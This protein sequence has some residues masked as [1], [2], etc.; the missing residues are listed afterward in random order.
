MDGQPSRRARRAGRP[1]PTAPWPCASR[2]P[3][4]SS[5][6]EGSLSVK[7]TDGG[8]VETLVKPIPI[9][10][11]KLEVEFYPEGGDLVA[12]AANRV[13]FQARTTLGKPADL[14][15]PGRGRRPAAWSPTSRR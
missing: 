12:G 11:K 8:N 15:G 4:R 7:F 6:G 5:K 14:E 3:S 1:A 9:V 2:C 10:L 13:Y